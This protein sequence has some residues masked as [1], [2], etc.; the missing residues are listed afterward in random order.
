MN[1]LYCIICERYRKFENPKNIIPLKKNILS[2]IGSKCQ[3]EDEKLFQ[4]EE[5]IEIFK[6]LGLIQDI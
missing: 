3:N 5:P 4:K 2:I 6:V 1:K